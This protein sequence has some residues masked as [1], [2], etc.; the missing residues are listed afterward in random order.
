[1]DRSVDI[2]DINLRDIF[3]M[4]LTDKSISRP[5]IKKDIIEV[6]CSDGVIDLS[7]A[8]TGDVQYKN[9]TI[10]LSLIKVDNKCEFLKFQS[11]FDNLFHGKTVKLVFE[12]DEDFYWQGVANIEHSIDKNID[13]VK[14]TI[15]AYPYKY[16]I[17]E[18]IVIEEINAEKVVICT[19]LRKWVSPSF[20]AT[21]DMQIKFNNHSYAIG[22]RETIF[23]G[24][25]FKQGENIVEVIGNGTLEIKYQE[26]SL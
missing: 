6:P 20:K 11:D 25:V 26:R 8:L 24:L 9:R 18:T 1:M 2:N 19:N 13:K 23:A 5:E 16:K 15:D 7:K 10:T 12:E 14:I 3:D 21:A 22:T 17:D 4:L